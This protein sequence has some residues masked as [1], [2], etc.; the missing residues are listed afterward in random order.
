MCVPRSEVGP[1]WTEYV[2]LA[3]VSIQLAYVFRVEAFNTFT[4]HIIIGM[5]VFIAIFLIIL[6]L[7]F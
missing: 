4:F 6:N 5:Y 1:L 7:L 3:F 2:G